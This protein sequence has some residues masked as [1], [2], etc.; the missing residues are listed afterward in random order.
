M[1]DGCGRR[2]IAKVLG[3][4]EWKARELMARVE[5][6]QRAKKGPKKK[7]N[8]KANVEIGAVN[9]VHTAKTSGKPQIKVSSSRLSHEESVGFENRHVKINTRDTSMNVAVLSDIHYPYESKEAVSLATAYL[10]DFG[11][12]I[13]VLNGDIIDCYSISKYNKSISKTLTI[14]DELEIAGEALQGLV[15]EFPDSRILYL[16]GNHET[17]LERLISSNAPAL[18]HLPSLRINRLLELDKMGIEWISDQEDLYIGKMLFMHGEYVRKHAGSTA[19]AHFER[20][21][22]SV[23]VGHVHRLSVSWKRDKNGYHC[24]VE[25]GTLCDFNVEYSRFPDWQHGFTTMRFDGDDFSIEQHPIVGNKL[26]AG[27]KVYVA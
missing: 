9:N 17:R 4:T 10:K 19:R 27:S 8:R 12:E 23:L 6:E 14:Q 21:G 24:L 15:N 11:P 22:C 16:E 2:K 3:V 1:D 13:I 20:Y 18:G 26:V 25:N 5:K 7:R